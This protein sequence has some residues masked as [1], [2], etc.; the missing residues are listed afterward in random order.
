MLLTYGNLIIRAV[1]Q[2]KTRYSRPWYWVIRIYSKICVKWPLK[3]R[4][5]K[6]LNDKW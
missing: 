1:Y 6:D 2:H 4:Q 5:N 3:N